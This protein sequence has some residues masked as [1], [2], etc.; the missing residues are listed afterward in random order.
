MPS[1]AIKKIKGAKKTI[2]SLMIGI[3]FKRENSTITIKSVGISVIIDG[4]IPKRIPVNNPSHIVMTSALSLVA[5][6][7][8][9]RHIIIKLIIEK[10]KLSETIE[11]LKAC[12]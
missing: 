2:V 1:A 9:V 3:L 5:F 7:A 4:L 8:F 11:E 12:K 6:I 10:A